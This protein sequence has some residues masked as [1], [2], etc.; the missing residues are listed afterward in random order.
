MTNRIRYLLDKAAEGGRLT[1]EEGVS[2]FECRDLNA[3]GHAAD[4]VTRRLHP[5][6]YRT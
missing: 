2:L 3:L 6:P 1:L 4:R 5:E